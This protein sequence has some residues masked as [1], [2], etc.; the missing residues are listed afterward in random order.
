MTPA[1]LHPLP[2]RRTW[3]LRRG[4]W[5][6]PA[7]G[8]IMGILNVT[9]DSFSDGGRYTA[10]ELALAHARQ[11]IQEGAHIIDIGGESTRPGS[12]EIDPEEELRRTLPIITALRAEQPG[13]LISIDTRHALVA[14]A[15]LAAGADI[16]NDITALASPAMLELCAA[17]PCGIILMHKQGDPATMQLHPQY[18]DVVGEVRA[19]FEQRVQLAEQAGISPARLCLDPGIGFGKTTAHNLSLISHLE[20]LR[21][22]GLPLLMAL[23]RK[24]FLG[25]LLG[26]PALPK[27]SP[28]PTVAMSLLAATRGADLH[29]VHDIPPLRQALTLHHAL[30]R[31]GSSGL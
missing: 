28:L 7:G 16:V 9:P 25:D 23:S 19:F 21:V 26:D 11:M 12:Q 20:E 14:A 30:Q 17:Q 31:G 15:A 6:L 2:P 3:R 8:G 4:A 27:T 5:E 18:A 1:P 13:I 29:R 24:R 22:R 10:P